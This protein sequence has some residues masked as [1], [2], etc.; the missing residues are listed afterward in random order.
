MVVLSGSSISQQL[1]LPNSCMPNNTPR[2]LNEIP[3]INLSDPQAK[4]LIIKAIQEFVFSKLVKHGISM[5]L[6][7]DFEA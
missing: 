1:V 2:L 6:I 3:E 5:D 7:A 4:T